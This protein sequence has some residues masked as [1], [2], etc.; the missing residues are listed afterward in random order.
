MNE[1]VSRFEAAVSA[2]KNLTERPSNE[3]LLQI[4]SLYKQATEGDNQGE[5]PSNPFDIVSK[6]KFEAWFALK[7]KTREEAM[8]EYIE[9]IQK[10]N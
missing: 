10:L 4:Y 2:S 6:A 1:L 3:V 9:L 5:P 7:G 8:Q